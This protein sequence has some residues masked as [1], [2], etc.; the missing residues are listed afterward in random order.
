MSKENI[1]KLLHFIDEKAKKVSSCEYGLPLYDDK[2]ELLI[3]Q[4]EEFIREMEIDDE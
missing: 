2:E 1:R 3:Y 4:V